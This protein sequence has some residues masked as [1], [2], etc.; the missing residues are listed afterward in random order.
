[1]RVKVKTMRKE[2]RNMHRGDMSLLPVHV[3]KL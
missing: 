2:G 3:G 1:M